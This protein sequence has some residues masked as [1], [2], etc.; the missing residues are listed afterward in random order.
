MGF[1]VTD[2][3]QTR[4][5][6]LSG[7]MP[8]HSTTSNEKAELIKLLSKARNKLDESLLLIAS[9]LGEDCEDCKRRRKEQEG[10]GRKIKEGSSL[11][12]VNL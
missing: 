5:D 11:Q 3:A 6:L 12:L 2:S 8:M 10:R 7:S 1:S 4:K 9:I